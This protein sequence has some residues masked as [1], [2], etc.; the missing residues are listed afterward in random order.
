[1]KTITVYLENEEYEQAKKNKGDKTWKE[2]VI[3]ESSNLHQ[4]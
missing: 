4:S 2:V 1:M 3:G